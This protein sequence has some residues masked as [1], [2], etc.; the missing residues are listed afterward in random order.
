MFFFYDNRVVT[1]KIEKGITSNLK[2]LFLIVL[3]YNK[4]T[5][6]FSKVSDGP[7]VSRIPGEKSF[8]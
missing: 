2:I 5:V 1:T 7:H 8:M 4:Y 3:F 6:D